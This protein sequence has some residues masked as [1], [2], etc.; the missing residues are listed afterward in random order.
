M[1]RKAFFIALVITGIVFGYS[2][3]FAQ[4]DKERKQV[5]NQR[6]EEEKRARKESEK[7]QKERFKRLH[8]TSD[9]SGATVEINGRQM[10]TTPL[11]L[12]VEEYVYKGHGFWLTSKYLATPV[13]LTLSKEGC[14]SK[15]LEITTGPFEWVNAN[16]TARHIYYVITSPDF[17]LKLDQVGQ[18]LGVNPL[19]DKKDGMPVSEGAKPAELTEATRPKMSV[20]EVVKR[21]LPAV[22]I[23]QSSKGSGSGF[24]ILESGVVVTNRHVVEGSDQVSV[25]T[26]QGESYQSAQIF[27]HPSRDLALV[28]LRLPEGK[29]FPFLPLAN[30][31]DVNVGAEAIAIGSPGG[32]NS[33]LA[34]TVTRGIVS[35]FRQTDAGLLLQTDAAIN[36]GNSGGPLLNLYGDV[37][38][39][40]TLK[41]VI[42][43]KEGLGFALFVSEIYAML[44][45]HLNFDMPAPQSKK[46]V[47]AT[48]SS[49]PTQPVGVSVQI[50]SE[51]TGA[52]VFVDGEF[53]G[54]TPSKVQVSPGERKIKITRPNHKDWERAIK[55]QPNEEKTINALLEQITSPPAVTSKPSKSQVP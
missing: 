27:T 24:F 25:T 38:G 7:A 14:V 35:A 40:N 3:A 31:A 34:N 10:G 42:P 16:G 50:T 13:K 12:P 11:T 1:K 54:S 53:V 51:P 41:I 18:F 28:K 6:R 37:I 9:P 17:H 47:A 44:K 5:E 46:T 52:E 23:I 20:E 39:V 22:T 32:V 30:P 43:G 4:S 2:V 15:T 49:P 29:K 26:S 55:I 8:I 33:I 21:S 36:S 45:E 48:N 19:A